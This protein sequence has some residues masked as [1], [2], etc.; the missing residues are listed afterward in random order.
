M[1]RRG[2]TWACSSLTASYSCGI[3]ADTFGSLTMFAPGVRQS[4]PCSHRFGF[5]R[6]GGQGSRLGRAQLPVAA[7]LHGSGRPA[8]LTPQRLSVWI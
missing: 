5:T 3:D 7:G 2:G 1:W 8:P 6:E 4:L